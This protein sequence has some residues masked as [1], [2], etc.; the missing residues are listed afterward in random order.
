MT[1]TVS[2]EG[3]QYLLLKGASEYILGA[4]DK[5]HYWDTDEIVNLN[6]NIKQEISENI[7]GFA[8]QTLRTL[9]VGYKVLN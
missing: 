7:H 4:C 2:F 3:K 5:I 6:E 8:K 9:C 1:T